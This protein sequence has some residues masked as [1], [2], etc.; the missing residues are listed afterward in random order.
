V[1]D[2]F[3][4]SKLKKALKQNNIARCLLDG[5]MLAKHMRFNRLR[6]CTHILKSIP[7]ERVTLLLPSAEVIHQDPFF[8]TQIA[9]KFGHVSG[10][11]GEYQALFGKRSHRS[12]LKRLK[13]L[14]HQHHIVWRVTDGAKGAYT[15]TA[16]GT[17]YMP[18][19]SVRVVDATGA[20]DAYVGGFETGHLLGY[21]FKQCGAMGTH[22]AARVVETWG[23]R[24][25][26]S[27]LL[28]GIRGGHNWTHYAC[29]CSSRG[30]ATPVRHPFK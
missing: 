15:V 11:W 26:K 28:C 4:F 29:D 3:S 16:A 24:L 25:P 10:N 14:A 2:R 30:T 9:L 27:D 19:L 5:F 7:R 6:L 23:T 1:S 17:E 18:A 21:P 8:F 12:M 20:G 22:A 13:R